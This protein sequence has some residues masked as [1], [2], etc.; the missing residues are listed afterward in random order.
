[1]KKNV[2]KKFSI[3]KMQFARLKNMKTI[4]GGDGNGGPIGG[5]DK[6]GTRNQGGNV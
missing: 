2:E 6:K 1:M 4:V 3:E 5:T